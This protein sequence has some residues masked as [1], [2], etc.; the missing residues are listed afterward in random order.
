MQ[1]RSPRNFSRLLSTSPPPPTPPKS[2]VWLRPGYS[3]KSLE[4]FC[5]IIISLHRAGLITYSTDSMQL[6]AGNCLHAANKT[7][8]PQKA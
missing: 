5:D 4:A 8:P 2:G 6:T 7:I 1:F 3:S